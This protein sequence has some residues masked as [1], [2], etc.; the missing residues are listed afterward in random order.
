MPPPPLH[1]DAGLTVDSLVSAA[2]K[3]WKS[4]LK[5]RPKIADA[6]ADPEENPDLFEEGWAEALAHE[7]EVAEGEGVGA[8]V[9]VEEDSE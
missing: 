6:I 7:K 5:A 4:E 3:Q 2:V 1:R 9:D 8:L